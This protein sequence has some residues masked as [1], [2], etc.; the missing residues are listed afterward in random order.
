MT[1]TRKTMTQ[2]ALEELISQRIAD[3]LATYDANRN[4]GDNSRSHDSGSGERRTVHTTRGCTDK[5]FLNCQPLNF[6]GTKGA[7]GL[8]DWF[9]KMEY[10]FHI[11]NCTVECQVKTVGHDV[12]YEMSL[13]TLMKKM[14]KAYCLRTLL[15]ARMLPEES[16]KV[17]KYSGGLPNNIQGN[18]MSARPKTLQEAIELANDLMDQKVRAYADRQADNKRRMN[19]NSRDNNAQ[20]LPYKRQNVARAYSVGPSEKKEYARTLP[21][22]NKCK[23]HHNGPCTVTCANYKRVGHLTRDCRSPTAANNQRTLTYFECGNQGHY[24]SECLKLKNQ[25]RGNQVGSSKARGRVYALG[26]GEADQS[27]INVEDEA[28]A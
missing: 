22:C 6:K 16:N 5:E 18:V 19:N 23:F 20:Q 11:S 7:V 1:S 26:G 15:R 27:L 13:K 3:A 12:A 25:N 10:V 24:R 21:L 28:D 4:N 14:T 8:P 2:E 17:E 9:E